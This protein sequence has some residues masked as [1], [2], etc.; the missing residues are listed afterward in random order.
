MKNWCTYWRLKNDDSYTIKLTW[1]IPNNC[2]NPI[3]LIRWKI[4]PSKYWE[5]LWQ[6]LVKFDK[7][8][9]NLETITSREDEKPLYV[10]SKY[11]CTCM[12]CRKYRHKLKNY[13]IEKVQTYRN[14][15]TAKNQCISK[16]VVGKE[17][18]KKN[19]E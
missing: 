5:Y 19:K 11:K 1:R 16:K 18:Q 2:G 4:P 7:M 15:T 3:I 13:G 14:V 12:T 8:S 9:K 17:S 10:K 6:I